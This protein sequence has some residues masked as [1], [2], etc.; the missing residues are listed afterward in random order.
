MSVAVIALGGKQYTVEPGKI[1][2][3]S[4][5]NAEPGAI[6]ETPDLLDGGKTV[7]VKVVE[8]IAGEKGHGVKFRNK[9]RYIRHYGYRHQE[10][11]VE[12]VKVA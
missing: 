7:T 4:R 3:V 11:Q 10:T 12:V 8:H 2:N 9:T 1:I 5:F 6:L